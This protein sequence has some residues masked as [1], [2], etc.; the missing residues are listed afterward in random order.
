MRGDRE[1]DDFF[2]GRVRPAAPELHLASTPHRQSIGGRCS[3]ALL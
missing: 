2:K 3:G 1:K